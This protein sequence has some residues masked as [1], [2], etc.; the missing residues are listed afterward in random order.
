M[1][2]PL[3]D[4]L[5]EIGLSNYEAGVYLTLLEHSPASAGFVAKK[6]RY[7]RSTVYAALDKLTA[8]G[9][10]GTTYKN[11]VKQFMAEQPKRL[12][13][14]L[15]EEERT[16]AKRAELFSKMAGELQFLSRNNTQVPN[17][18]FFEGWESLKKIYLSM[19][20]A[21]PQNAEMHIIRSEFYWTPEWKFIFGNEWHDV[22]KRWRSEL[23]IKTQLLINDSKEERKH[24]PFYTSRKHTAAKF[25]PKDQSVKDFAL[26]M[27]GDTV[28][29]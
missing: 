1:E 16:V 15:R 2:N 3:L 10:V 20:Q 27:L 17:V 7:S 25:L 29:I 6:L 13:E 11:G 21:A 24:M 19:L 5:V 28:S 22:V 8:K 4:Q 26:Y 18:I 14:M 9:L 23:N 12:G